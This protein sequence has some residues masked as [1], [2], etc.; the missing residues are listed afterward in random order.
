MPLVPGVRRSRAGTASRRLDARRKCALPP[1][2]EATSTDS[3]YEEKS[4]AG[5]IDLVSRGE[6]EAS[7]NVLHAHRGEQPVI[8]TYAALFS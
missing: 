5:L 3:V 1:R 2:C 4:I 8:N 7:S 6:F